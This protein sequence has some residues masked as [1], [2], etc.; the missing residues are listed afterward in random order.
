MLQEIN[1]AFSVSVI[2]SYIR[3]AT[4]L[5]SLYQQGF[6]LSQHSVGQKFMH[7]WV[8]KLSFT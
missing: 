4:I 2:H 3:I 7:R 5:C 1:D 8:G 6:I